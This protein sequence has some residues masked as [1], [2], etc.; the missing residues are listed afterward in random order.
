MKD[1]DWGFVIITCFVVL[2]FG[3][4]YGV[5]KTESVTYHLITPQGHAA[6]ITRDGHGHVRCDRLPAGWTWKEVEK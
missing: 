1:I 3:I 6:V 5:S 2:V 4:C